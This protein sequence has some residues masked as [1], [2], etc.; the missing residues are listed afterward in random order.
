MPLNRNLNQSHNFS[1]VSYNQRSVMAKSMTIG[2]SPINN[3]DSTIEDKT[4]T[5]NSIP[6]IKSGMSIP[7]KT[8][9]PMKL[10]RI[11]FLEIVDTDQRSSIYDRKDTRKSKSYPQYGYIF[12]IGESNT[13][14]FIPS[15][16][17]INIYKIGEESSDKDPLILIG[18]SS[19]ETSGAEVI[20]KV[21]IEPKV[22]AKIDIMKKVETVKSKSDEYE[23][24]EETNLEREIISDKYEL[25]KETKIEREII[26]RREVITLIIRCSIYIIS[27]KFIIIYSIRIGITNRI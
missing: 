26:I 5:I 15:D 6:F 21:G 18:S 1:S 11:L 19:L 16:I 13:D 27:S 9:N 12:N 20:L 4:I 8:Y 2:D 25:Q 10:E 23:L 7:V 24:R 22:L 17:D 14:I 3:N